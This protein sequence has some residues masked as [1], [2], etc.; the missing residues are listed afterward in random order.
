MEISLVWPSSDSR[1]WPLEH[2]LPL[3]VAA[4]L[5]L[6]FCRGWC[7][8]LRE[9][10]PFNSPGPGV[11]HVLLVCRTGGSLGWGRELGHETGK[12]VQSTVIKK[13]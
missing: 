7:L 11:S 6:H 9:L 5:L 1:S 8:L 4:H 10:H 3:D 2:D 13:V 12:P